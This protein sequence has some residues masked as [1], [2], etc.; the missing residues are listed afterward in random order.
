MFVLYSVPWPE[1]TLP[2]AEDVV[3]DTDQVVRAHCSHQSKE[4]E[5]DMTS[6]KPACSPPS[7]PADKGH[8]A[9]DRHGHWW[10]VFPGDAPDILEQ[11]A[12]GMNARARRRRCDALRRAGVGVSAPAKKHVKKMRQLTIDGLPAPPRVSVRHH[13]VEGRRS[14]VP[15]SRL[16][17]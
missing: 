5:A 11:C 17:F 6:S 9:T 4:E 3:S 1:D 12:G 16:T 8:W 13:R 10:P 7:S 15:R 14:E 2:S